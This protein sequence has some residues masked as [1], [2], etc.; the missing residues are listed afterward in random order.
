[1]RSDTGPTSG[2]TS[3]WGGGGGFLS[4]EIAYRVTKLRA[5]LPSTVPAGHLHVPGGNGTDADRVRIVAR[6]VPILRAAAL[7]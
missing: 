7:A 6:C 3:V 1:M 5:T 4:N 2:S